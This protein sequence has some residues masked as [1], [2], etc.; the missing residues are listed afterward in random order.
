MRRTERN[1]ANCLEDASI[2]S[3]KG[4]VKGTLIRTRDAESLCDNSDQNDKHAN[5]SQR[6]CLC[7]LLPISIVLNPGSNISYLCNIPIETQGITNAHG[8]DNNNR[9][10][11]RQQAQHGDIPQIRPYRRQHARNAISNNDPKRYHA[12]KRKRPLRNRDGNQARPPKTMLHRALE[13][14]APAHLAIYHDQ[15]DRPVH[16]DR[17]DHQE[18][19]AG[20]QSRLAQRVRLPDDARA[21]DRVRHVHERG[22]QTGLGPLPL[23]L[24]PVVHAVLV[25]PGAR[26]ERDGRRFDVCEEGDDVSRASVA[27]PGK[28]RGG[29]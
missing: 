1:N 23:L 9:P 8:E 28:G 13:A 15:P 20:E 19:D 16:R 26:G 12:P 25:A 7:Q 29:V 18:D 10:S 6:A 3:Q 17:Q 27:A 14:I 21:D 11:I 2:D 24:G 4:Q 5:Q 22:A